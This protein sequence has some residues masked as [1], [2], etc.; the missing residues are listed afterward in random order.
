MTNPLDQLTILVVGSGERMQK[1][2]EQALERH[3]LE[4]ESVTKESIVEATYA[5]APDLLLLLGDAA[6]DGGAS[7]LA[8][9]SGHPS[10]STVPIVLLAEAGSESNIAGSFRHGI[11]AVIPRTASADGMARQI[12]KVSHE[13]PER[14]GEVGGELDEATVEELVSLFSQQLRS[15]I[16]SVTSDDGSST[17]VVLREGRPVAE[18]VEELVDR[19]K[20]LLAS[21]S[22]PLRYEFHESPTARLD[23]LDGVAD[24]REGLDAI[25][26]RR[27]LLIEQNAARADVLVQE[28]RNR[29]ALVVVADGAGTGLERARMHD[30]DV[31]VLDG[32]GVEG[33][34]TKA[35]RLLRRD[36]KLRWASLLVVDAVDLWPEADAPPSL[37][38]LERSLHSLM[39]PDRDLAQR[40]AGQ[41]FFETRLELVGPSRLLRS[42]V[43]T[44]LGLQLTTRHPRVRVEIDLAEGLVVGA[45]AFAPRTNKQLAEGPAALAAWMGL[46][47]GRVRVAS[48]EAPATA[49]LM[50]PVDDAIAAAQREEPPLRVSVPPPTGL[51]DRPEPTGE[52]IPADSQK[53]L[54]RLEDLVDRLA[55]VVPE[56]PDDASEKPATPH[57]LVPSPSALLGEKPPRTKIPGPRKPAPRKSA[58]KKR[59]ATLMLGNAGV[60]PA[61]KP[62]PP[63]ED[64]DDIPV[65]EATAEPGALAKPPAAA[66]PAPTEPAPPEPAGQPAFEATPAHPTASPQAP[67]PFPMAT[68]VVAPV[69]DIDFT[70]SRKGRLPV[71]LGLGAAG[72]AL[73][74]IVGGAT[75][76]SFLGSDPEPVREPSPAVDTE[77]TAPA[78]TPPTSVASEPSYDA[79]A[80][81]PEVEEPDAGRGRE[82]VED[83]E[84]ADAEGDSDE[85]ELV[86]PVADL[87]ASEGGGTDAA[88]DDARPAGGPPSVQH[89]IRSA[90]FDR[91]RGRLRDAEISYLRVLRRERRNARALAGLTRIA[92]GRSEGRQ[93]VRWAQRLV[94]FQPRN[95]NNHVLLGDA[96]R[97]AGHGRAAHAS[98]RRALELQ[99]GHRTATQRL[100]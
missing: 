77:A 58:P 97:A 74:L 78:P 41:K 34:A 20:P 39:R 91:N 17:Q 80:P 46:G 52:S 30:P 62:R 4:V 2:L 35:L 79:S 47:S 85:T 70:P 84:G 48:K 25:S 57:G 22:S 88:R 11:V 51:T 23:L 42:L 13:L 83:T 19:I 63:W 37:S 96:H 6:S 18:A 66:A 94:R 1:A 10:A 90:N 72:A 16:L 76:W 27:I 59:K 28:L 75:A 50:A 100:R 53:L 71:L 98:W 64:V 5:A 56:E 38:K 93:A 9:L 24:D 89:L 7:A 61:R 68:E 55:G 31:V 69:A 86:E 40:A 45:R 43:S 54:G 26:G 67:E 95:P 44:D 81:E 65:I 73:L 3:G 21:Q 49:N 82:V 8:R 92:M 33:W 60:A 15:G 12:A 29:G 36:P 14:T 87:E 32:S 99:P